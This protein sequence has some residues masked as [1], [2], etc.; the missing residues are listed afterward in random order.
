[1]RARSTACLRVPAEAHTSAAPNR[2]SYVRVIDHRGGRIRRWLM[3]MM[4]RAA[5]KRMRVGGADIAALRA[6]QARIDA[7]LGRSTG[8]MRMV[9]ARDAPVA[10]DWLEG[11]D[12]LPGRVLLYLHGGA[13][14]FRYPRVHAGM[15]APWCA[16]LKARALMVDYRLAPEHPFPAGADD[17]HAAYRWLLRK[18][19]A[20][21]QIV[22]GGDSAGGTLTLSTLHAIKA[23]GEPM[24]ACAVLLSPAV[25]LTMSG[26]S[27]ATHARRDPVFSLD[28]LIGLRNLYVRP[29]QMLDARASPL[30]GDYHGFPPLLFQVGSEEVLLD[31]TLRAAARAHEAGVSVEAEIWKHMAHVF[32]AQHTLPQAAAAAKRIVQFIAHHTRWAP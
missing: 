8:A 20:G 28:T 15:V 24:P 14:A 6:G 32:L 17:C 9:S 10:A 25:D 7:R 22:L 26:A 27:F 1:M 31:D 4:L 13:F 30:F 19:Y 5:A 12:S 23:A 11:D 3:F 21:S 2:P 29:E 18:G 16:A